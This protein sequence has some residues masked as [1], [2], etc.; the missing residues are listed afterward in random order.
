MS[1][2]DHCQRWQWC[3]ERAD[4]YSSAFSADHDW[5]IVFRFYAALHLT[6]GYL[7][8]KGNLALDI[9]SHGDR[10]A[11]I[12]RCPELNNR[13]RAH[14]DDLRDLSEQVRYDPTFRAKPEDHKRAQDQLGVVE[15]F[16]KSKLGL[17][18]APEDR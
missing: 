15:S 1:K 7:L 4:Q 13:F 14:Y 11:A 8:T 18:K 9:K 3:R 2:D 5:T 17:S 6:H 10:K 16:L 12:K